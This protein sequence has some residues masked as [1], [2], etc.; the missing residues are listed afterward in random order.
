[1]AVLAFLQYLFLPP[2]PPGPA[3]GRWGL[4]LAGVY[5]ALFLSIALFHVVGRTLNGRHRLK[6]AAFRR[7]TG[8]GL[9]L[10]AL[11]LCLLAWRALNLPV[12]SIRAFLALQLAATVFAAL[13]LLWWLRRRYPPALAAYEWE[14]KKRA[15]LP[16]AAGGAV[17]SARRKTPARHRR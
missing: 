6:I 10:Q 8:T 11:G 2:G 14:E 17:E 5:L 3:F 9:G 16:R 7:I 1:M 4:V 15:Y 12:L 13:Y